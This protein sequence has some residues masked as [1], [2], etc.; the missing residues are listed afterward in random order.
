MANP[1]GGTGF[2]GQ[3]Q[4]RDSVTK[5][6][7]DLY[8]DETAGAL[9]VALYCYDPDDLAWERMLQPAVDPTKGDVDYTLYYYNASDLLEYKCTNPVHGA[10]TS[11]TT[12]TITRFVYNASDLLIDKQKLTGS[13]DGRAALGWV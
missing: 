5:D 11:A 1:D 10:A 9:K 13:V 7:I 2:P 6:P 3:I 12:W 8:G 4:A